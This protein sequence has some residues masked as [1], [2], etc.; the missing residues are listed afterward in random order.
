MARP[1]GGCVS[2]T[3]EGSARPVGATME[4]AAAQVGALV[5]AEITAEVSLAGGTAISGRQILT[6]A[7]PREAAARAAWWSLA[8]PAPPGS[9]NAW[10]VVLGVPSPS[11]APQRVGALPP[12]AD[13]SPA[14]FQAAFAQSLAAAALAAERRVAVERGQGEVWVLLASPCGVAEEGAGDAGLGATAAIAAVEAR[15]NDSAATI[16]PWITSDG[17]GILAHASFRDDRETPIELARRVGGAA[18]RALAAPVLTTEIAAAARAATLDLL[19]RAEGPEAGALATFA[20]A[21]AP[22]HPS[23]VEPLGL[24]GQVASSALEDVRLHQ[25][26]LASGPLRV[27]VLANADAAQA[28]AAGDAVDRWLTPG[29]AR[30]ACRPGA[31]L[32]RSPAATRAAS[33]RRP[34]RARDDRRADPRARRPWPRSRRARAPRPRRRS[35]PAR[36]RLPAGRR[37]CVGADPRRIA[38]AS[39]VIDVRAPEGGLTA[40]VTEVKLMLARLPQSAT[41]ADLDRAF[42]EQARLEQE[43]RADP[44]RRLVDLW[45]GR[46]PVSRRSRRSPPSAP[47]SP[48]RSERRL[49]DRRRGAPRV[50]KHKEDAARWTRYR[51]GPCTSRSSALSPPG[52]SLWQ[53]QDGAWTLTA[54]VRGTF[55]LVHGREAVLADAQ[56]PVVGDRYHASGGGPRGASLYAASELVPYKPRADVV[57]VGSAFAPEQTPVEALIARVAVEELDKSVGVIGDRRW[58]PAPT[59]SSRAR[60]SRFDRCRS[61]TS[62]RA[63]PDNPVGFDLARTPTL[64]ELALPTSRPSTTR[65][66]PARR[67]ASAPSRPPP[68]PAARS[69]TPRRWPGRWRA[70]KARSP[71]LRLRLL[72]RGAARSADRSPPAQRHDRARE[73]PPRTPALRGQAPHVRPRS[74]LVSPDGERSLEIALRCDT[75]WIDTDRALL[76]LS[77]RGLVGLGTAEAEGLDT[78]VVAAESKG[79]EL[80]FKHIQRMLRDGASVSHDEDLA[81]EAH[82]LAVRHDRVKAAAGASITPPAASSTRPPMIT[83]DD[84]TT[85][86]SEAKTLDRRLPGSL[87]RRLP[88]RSIRRCRAPA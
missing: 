13:V 78:L 22:D 61:A 88:P 28:Q 59:G 24:W 73:P 37:Q 5:R 86:E 56:E 8:A 83:R 60:P 55:S 69:S 52:T 48:T 42:A 70:K 10:V 27:A 34:A 64:G 40:A 17:I 82:P 43:G 80:R 75:L 77:W 31:P 41:D 45:A 79:K 2:V 7:D 76:S 72:Q 62:A 16:E 3:I 53:A 12:A 1:R 46:G 67:W 9:P 54:C 47:S 38:R 57:L 30:R 84:S 66:T 15:R 49:A 36:R 18:A 58:A 14:R 32:P 29:P 4:V 87:R 71:R 19:G 11:T 35:R 44:R 26:S 23:W 50:A 65:P 85:G 74:F 6:A 25:Q 39:L 33:R 51:A 21:L 81:G 20:P 63:R 68:R